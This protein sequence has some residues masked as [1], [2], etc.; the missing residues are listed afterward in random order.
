MP[1]SP[2]SKMA[3][4]IAAFT[5]AFALGSM[6]DVSIVEVITRSPPGACPDRFTRQS[7]AAPIEWR[8]YRSIGSRVVAACCHPRVERGTAVDTFDFVIVG[9]GSAASVLAYR[10]SADGRT[11][12]R[13]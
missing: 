5:A 8:R 2:V 3:A 10:L 7:L 9:G 11:D 1:S 6:L 12:A 4:S 13:T